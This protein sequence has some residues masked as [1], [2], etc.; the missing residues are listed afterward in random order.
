MKAT[1]A[2]K[3]ISVNQCWQGKRYKTPLYSNFEKEMLLK[4]PKT[5]LAAP[6]FGVAL[7]FGFSNSTSD[8]DNPIKPTLDII[9]KKYNIN[10][11]DI[12]ELAVKKQVVKKGNEFIQYT[13]YYL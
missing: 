10:D 9:Q 6:P 13:I 1:I 12:Y 5:S 4:M 8:I 11:R 2:I 7:V 3:P